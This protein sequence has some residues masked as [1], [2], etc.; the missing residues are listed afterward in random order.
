MGA[1]DREDFILLLAAASTPPAM[2]SRLYELADV[3]GRFRRQLNPEPDGL[4]EWRLNLAAG[5][6]EALIGMIEPTAAEIVAFTYP[7]D[8]EATA[9][10]LHIVDARHA[11]LRAQLGYKAAA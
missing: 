1:S 4:I 11:R 6:V 9:E 5:H 3:L 8:D 10:A 2:T 7:G